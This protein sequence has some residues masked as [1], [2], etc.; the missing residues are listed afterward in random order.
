M[1]TLILG[2]F[3]KVEMSELRSNMEL[4]NESNNYGFTDISSEKVRF[5]HFHNKEVLRIDN[6][7]YLHVSENGG[8]RILDADENCY[9]IRPGEG[10]Y[11]H[12]TVKEEQPHFIK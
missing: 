4:R 12:W 6:P 8:H 5:Y 7:L 9:Y 2:L 1:T 10:W 11:I 3:L